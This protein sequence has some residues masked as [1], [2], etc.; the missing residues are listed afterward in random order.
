MIAGLQLQYLIGWV[1]IFGAGTLW[2]L[3]A[4][5]DKRRGDTLSETVW[6]AV[7]HGKVP[8][9]AVLAIMVWVTLHFVSGGA[10]A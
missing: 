8:R 7:R 1:V 3:R 9:L 2:E 6:V 10:W 4:L 5:I